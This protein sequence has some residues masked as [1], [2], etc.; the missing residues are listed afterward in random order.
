MNFIF[1]Y[2]TIEEDLSVNL[3]LS[4]KSKCKEMIITSRKN[5]KVN[6]KKMR[7]KSAFYFDVVRF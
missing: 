6:D 5:I 7:R 4:A 2:N 3:N 1:V